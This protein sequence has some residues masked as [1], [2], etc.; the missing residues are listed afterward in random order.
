VAVS[1]ASMGTA[2][3]VKLV[4]SR[5]VLPALSVALACAGECLFGV[6]ANGER[7]SDES[8]REEEGA[9]N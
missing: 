8:T 6:G 2:T 3:I 4:P 1:A 9:C 7:K 5:M